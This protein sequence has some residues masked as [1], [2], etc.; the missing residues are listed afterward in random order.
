M[1]LTPGSVWFDGRATQSST[2][3][4][5]G[6]SRYVA[7]H[8]RALVGINPEVIGAI[9]IDP[10]APLS[11]SLESLAGS[12]LLRTH[13]QTRPPEG[14]PL[15]IYHVTSPFEMSMDFDQVWPAWARGGDSRLVVTLHDLIPLI[16]YDDYVRAWGANGTA[17]MARLGLIR[18][19]HQL[20]TNSENT[21]RDAIEHLQIPEERVTVIHS[22]VSGQHASL[23]G[24]REE[25]E[26]ILQ[27]DFPRI[28]RGFVLY[29][30]GDDARK[31]LD[32][33][34]R[35]Y[36][37]LPEAL[38]ARHQL[39]IAF[40]VGPL[41][42]LEI[43]AMAQPL[44]IRPRDLILTG[45]V[46]DRQLAALY[47]ACHLFVFPSLYE[48][49]GL[50]VLEAM[51]CGAPVAASNTTSIPELLGDP[52]GTFDPAA[53]ADIA[54]GI[55]EVLEDRAILER[56]R[57]RSKRRVELY[58]WER[59]ARHTLEGYERAMQIPLERRG[60]RRRPGNRKRLAVIGPRPTM[61]GDSSYLA[62]LVTH[63]AEHAEVELVVSSQ[64]NGDDAVGVTDLGVA[65]RTDTEFDWLKGA[66]GYDRC[67]FVLDGSQ[68][69]LH[70]LELL[71]RVPGVVLLEDVRL[72]ELYR[73]LQRH[74][75]W[76]LPVWLE[77]KLMASY[78]ERVGRPIIRGIAYAGFEDNRV[79]MTAEIQQ[80]AERLLVHSKEQIELLEFDRGRRSAPIELVPF[81]IPEFGSAAPPD[82]TGPPVIVV[83][84]RPTPAV[85][86][87][88]GQIEQDHPGARV[89][90]QD[91]LDEAGLAGAD[92][93]LRLDSEA[94]AGRPSPNVAA[95]IAAGVPIFVSDIGWQGELPEPVVTRF[96]TDGSGAMLAERIR[97]LL[98]DPAERES[99]RAAQE[100]FAAENSFSRVA[101]RYAELLGL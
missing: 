16:L 43:R 42:K 93:A 68:S 91:D 33:T 88:L 65:V 69:H 63:L 37:Q 8:A 46:T 67:L 4:E 17:W 3:A 29:V 100:L 75:Y 40:R 78:G 58:T 11:P 54:R 7:E 81:A 72:L 39:V 14:G 77:D 55:R 76:Y 2:H 84:G 79:L 90:S 101:E 80:S 61:D 23:V 50:P 62:K 57:E 86:V 18:A 1:A 60:S 95:L 85:R 51:S 15:P 92:L 70:A 71:H 38:R 12:G 34:I 9:G 56:L 73:H 94:D 28:R 97:S 82:R 53:T 10:R 26:R 44:G 87:A 48:G 74:R 96:P 24:S 20:L 36:A 6:L 27:A 89:L 98:S 25:G 5:R 83:S 32:G 52:E 35:A 47:R 64:R 22:G 45:Y 59:V 21:A 99:I 49:A 30:G 13:R 31:N 66:R 19:A 41:R